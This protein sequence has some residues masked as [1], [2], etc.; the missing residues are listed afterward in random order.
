M[1]KRKLALLLAA[2]LC[3]TLLA[4]CAGAENTEIYFVAVDDSVPLTLPTDALPYT[5]G[6]T[7]YAPYTVFNASPGGVVPSYNASEQTLVLFRRG[8]RLIF[9]LADGTV[10]DEDKNERD[11]ATVYRGGML[12]VPLDFCLS[13]FGLSAVT[14]TS[15]SGY[16][17]LRFTTGNE[18]YDNELFVEKAENLIAYL[19]E[20]HENSTP[21]DE[22]PPDT[23][24][25]QPPADEPPH[26]EGTFCLA[27]TGAE[28]MAEAAKALADSEQRAAFF[29][30]AEEITAQPELVRALYAAGHTIG[31]TCAEDVEDAAIA[32][33]AANA[34][35]SRTLHRKTLFALLSSAQSQFCP[36]YCIFVRPQTQPALEELILQTQAGQTA[37]FVCGADAAGALRTLQNAGAALGLL[38]ETS[39]LALI[40]VPPEEEE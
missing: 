35:L 8:A 18:V 19:A 28:N 38:R 23:N 22:P 17:I 26:A 40:L 7:R 33:E 21:A 13:H 32:L 24:T 11:L 30:T 3:L 9:D 15:L 14:L 10:T 20:Q 2:V 31:V 34:A 12:Y 5:S 16:T 25:Q 27:V 29:L 4:P 36:D 1:N 39:P 6:G 37:L